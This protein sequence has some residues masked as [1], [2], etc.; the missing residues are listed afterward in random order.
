[1]K[2]TSGSETITEMGYRRR[3]EDSANDRSKSA[4]LQTSC[5]NIGN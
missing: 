2:E 1:M 4:E 5:L 3:K